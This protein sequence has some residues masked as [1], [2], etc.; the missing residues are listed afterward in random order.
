MGPLVW[1][2]CDLFSAVILCGVPSVRSEFVLKRPNPEPKS[3]QN[4]KC[5]YKFSIL[6]L[7]CHSM[8]S[9]SLYMMERCLVVS[10]MAPLSFVKE[11]G[12]ICPIRHLKKAMA[13]IKPGIKP[14]EIVAFPS[15][16]A[17]RSLAHVEPAL[18]Q[19]LQGNRRSELLCMYAL[20]YFVMYSL[21][22]FHESV[23]TENV[24]ACV[25]SM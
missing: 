11:C 25:S 7:F 8:R 23:H 16:S 12:H 14:R 15:Q 3:F 10:P 24:Y 6:H 21:K 9:P 1:A 13:V 4:G 19:G 2:E 18:G 5:L 20:I 22:E 17:A